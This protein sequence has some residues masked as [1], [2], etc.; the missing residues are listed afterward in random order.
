LP[1]HNSPWTQSTIDAAIAILGRHDSVGAAL[2]EIA[3][4]IGQP[5]SGSAL[6]HAMVSR[7]LGA[8][9]GWLRGG[10]AH[11]RTFS[12][13]DKTPSLAPKVS[14]FGSDDR[15]SVTERAHSGMSPSGCATTRIL[16]CPDAH[17]PFVDQLAWRT[18]LAAARE[19]RPDVL[20]IIGDFIDCYSVSS[21]TKDPARKVHFSDELAAANAALDEID[22]LRIPRVIFTE[23]NHETRL[24]R[25]VAD[26]APEFHGLVDMRDLLRVAAR[27]Y[28]WVP[29][30]QWVRVGKIAFTHDV[31]RAGVNAARQS[32][33]DFGGNLVFGHTHR[34]GVVYQGTVDGDQH[35]CLNVGWLGDYD[36]IDYKHQARARRDW[37]HGF[38]VVILDETG[39]GWCEFVPI[40]SG[41]CIVGGRVVSGRVAA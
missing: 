31:E 29:Y 16:V 22:A 23:G 13:G 30:K 40:L 39:C 18:F 41:R 33:V 14:A 37:Q 2:P 3:E 21:H 36:S 9:S 7:G 26:R 32:L 5:V 20:V 15:R 28:E 19:W 27:G 34:G 17:H 25:A 10:T 1:K 38:G 12:A 4:Q 24:S 6:K 11:G 35:V 8:P